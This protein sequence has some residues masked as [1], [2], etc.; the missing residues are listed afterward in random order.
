VVLRGGAVSRERGTPVGFALSQTLRN[1]PRNPPS[2]PLSLPESP[3]RKMSN[4]FELHTYTC[5]WCSYVLTHP[6]T[7]NVFRAVLI[8]EGWGKGLGFQ[9]QD[10]KLRISGVGIEN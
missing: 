2:L 1:A 7:Y 8:I 9:F 10:L 6:H 4:H 5:Y 3:P